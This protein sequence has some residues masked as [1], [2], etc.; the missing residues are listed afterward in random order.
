MIGIDAIGD[1]IILA[2]FPVDDEEFFDKNERLDLN[3]YTDPD[4]GLNFQDSQA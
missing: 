3:E 4:M 2:E 1:N